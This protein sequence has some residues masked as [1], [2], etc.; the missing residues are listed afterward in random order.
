[1]LVDENVPNSVTQF[2]FDRGHEVIRVQDAFPPGTPDPVVATVGDRL[3]AIVVSWDKDFD[4]LASRVPHGNKNRFRRLGR[5][6]FKCKE[7]DG[8]PRVEQEIDMI[9]AHYERC[10]QRLDLRMFVEILGV[11]RRRHGGE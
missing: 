1:M 2:F 10:R 5:I 11:T 6:T 7:S 3:S 4:R 8:R 9:E